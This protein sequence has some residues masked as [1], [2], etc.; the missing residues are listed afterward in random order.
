M[1]HCCFKGTEQCTEQLPVRSHHYIKTIQKKV[2]IA[3]VETFVLD[4]QC[5][6]GRSSSVW[7][8]VLVILQ[9]VIGFAPVENIMLQDQ[10]GENVY[11][12]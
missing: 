12:S 8:L 5:R 9:H 11:F 2:C 3:C 1:P 6:S 10:S 7:N 4:V